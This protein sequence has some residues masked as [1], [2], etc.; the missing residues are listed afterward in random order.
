MIWRWNFCIQND[1]SQWQFHNQRI[2]EK[3]DGDQVNQKPFSC[4][5]D[6]DKG[7]QHGRI[8]KRWSWRS[9]PNAQIYIDLMLLYVFSTCTFPDHLLQKKVGTGKYRLRIPRNGGEDFWRRTPEAWSHEYPCGLCTGQWESNYSPENYS[10]MA[11]AEN[12]L[13]FMFPNGWTLEN[14]LSMTLENHHGVSIYLIGDTSSNG[15][16]SIVMLVF[17]G[18]IFVRSCKFFCSPGPVFFFARFKSCLFEM[19]VS[20][21][22]FLGGLKMMVITGSPRCFWCKNTEAVTNIA[23]TQPV[24]SLST[25][26]KNWLVATQILFIFTPKIGE[27]SQFD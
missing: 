21:M 10:N 17:Q 23:E 3:K 19:W 14:H 15:W 1:K 4:I 11:I 8:K 24:V 7:F 13:I 9:K 2:W 26:D 18:A 20:N 12:H 6:D 27:D 16:F 25:H 22:I 5:W